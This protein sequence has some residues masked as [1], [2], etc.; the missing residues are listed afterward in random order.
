MRKKRGFH[1]ILYRFDG[2]LHAARNI[3]QA[4]PTWAATALVIGA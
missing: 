3:A 1:E 2:D 4:Q